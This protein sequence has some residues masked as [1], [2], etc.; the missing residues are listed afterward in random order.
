MSAGYHILIGYTSN[1]P[2]Q[3][4]N[5][6]NDGFIYSIISLQTVIFVISHVN[7][8]FLVCWDRQRKFSTSLP[9]N[10]RQL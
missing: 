10:W 7:E 8:I 4:F 3:S 6:L 1:N 9:S 2:L 5:S